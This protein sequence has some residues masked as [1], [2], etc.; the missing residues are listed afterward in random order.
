MAL[1]LA[2][3][4]GGSSNSS[5][6]GSTGNTGTSGTIPTKPDGSWL[7]FSPNPVA[8]SGYEGQSL[9]FSITATST[10][11]FTNPFNLAVVDS[12]GT[13]TSDVQVSALSDLKYM[14]ALRTSSKLSAGIH[15]AN[16]EVRLC[17]DS[18]VTCA[19]PLPGSPW[20][21]PLT[22]NLKSASEAAQRL[23]LSVP[24]LQAN[25]KAGEQ[26]VV[27]FDGV[28][29][30]D[31]VGQTFQ[32]GI[33]DPAGL[34]NSTITNSSQ[35]FT[36][37]LKTST[38]LQ[39][40][41]YTSNLEVRLCSDDPR[42]C[43]APLPGSPWLVPFKLTVTKPIG[44]TPLKQLAGVGAW[45]TYQGNV[46]HTGYVDASFDVS[47]FSAR[48][49]IPANGTA[50]K[51]S[52]AA[53]DS[54][55]VFMAYME[56]GQAELRGIK[57][58]DG[59][60]AWRASLGTVDSINP[61]AVGNGYVFVTTTTAGLDTLWVFSQLDGSLAYKTG[62]GNVNSA[63][64]RAPTVIGAD[65]YS[66]GRPYYGVAVRK[67]SSEKLMY[68]W[69]NRVDEGYADYN[70]NQPA[71]DSNYLY[72]YANGKLFGLSIGGGYLIWSAADTDD[73]TGAV[74]SVALSGNTA[75]VMGERIAAFD[76]FGNPHTRL[77]SVENKFTGA[78]AVGNN[79]VYAVSAASGALEARSVA[80]GKLQWTSES[81]SLGGFKSLVATRNLVFVSGATKTQAIDLATHKVVW[82]YDRGGELSI[83]SNGV[84]YILEAS[85]YLSAVNLQY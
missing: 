84:L 15:Q 35:G 20:I 27:N 11:T 14:A 63:G 38:S 22:V 36:A 30:G 24:S 82:T 31:L 77:W 53:I 81:M 5:N 25:S 83:S 44:L 76:T 45:S 85:G 19:K 23:V 51:I 72:V 34:S 78:L 29:K 64:S 41:E 21:V 18:P 10:R 79:M 49:N 47:Q 48:F 80:D 54:G 32:V 39:P 68:L 28:F 74:K 62:A 52:T 60:I 61:P 1:A 8:V 70:P 43:R 13:I 46:S 57:E 33:V 16:L 3:C 55:R 50:Q 37:T 12:S 69:T 58:A 56:Q 6:T 9:P 75:I 42:T 2:A 26:A 7:S 65:V 66:W 73:V 59:A 17:E 71:A 4:G 67:F 40:G